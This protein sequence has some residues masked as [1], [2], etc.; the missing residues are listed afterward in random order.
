MHWIRNSHLC[1][2]FALTVSS[3]FQ[4][5]HSFHMEFTTCWSW[6]KQE[7]WFNIQFD[8]S[9]IRLKF[10]LCF[11]FNLSFRFKKKKG[12]SEIHWASFLFFWWYD[13]QLGNSLNRFGQKAAWNLNLRTNINTFALVQNHKTFNPHNECQMKKEVRKK[14]NS[15]AF[16]SLFRS[17]KMNFF[18]FA[19]FLTGTKITT[20]REREIFFQL[21]FQ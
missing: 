3:T 21:F 15:R 1:T 18:F 9:G 17:C 2:Y 20:H 14:S 12:M 5:L 6:S 10:W 7:K 8:R 19:L 13:Q 16:F 4:A 11:W